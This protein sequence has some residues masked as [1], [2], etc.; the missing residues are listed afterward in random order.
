VLNAFRTLDR[1][2]AAAISAV[3]E[4]S[5]GATRES[6]ML[7]VPMMERRAVRCS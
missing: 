2:R 6:N 3:A 5:A 4:L 1:G 7:P